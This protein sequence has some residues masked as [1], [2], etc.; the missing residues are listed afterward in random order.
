M[1]GKDGKDYK[2]QIEGQRKSGRKRKK[3]GGFE[4]WRG[5]ERVEGDRGV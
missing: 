5:G 3:G 2:R 4:R 1:L